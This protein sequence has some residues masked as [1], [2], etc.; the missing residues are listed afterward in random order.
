MM[1]MKSVLVVMTI[2]V[3]V[4][5]NTEM[6]QYNAVE[7]KHLC[8]ILK[9]AEGEPEKIP[10]ELGKFMET[11]NVL[12]KLLRATKTSTK[13]YQKVIKM[14]S[15]DNEDAEF[16]SYTVKRRIAY[17]NIQHAMEKAKDIYNR[18]EEELI[19]ASKERALARN[20]LAHAIYGV[21]V[22][23]FPKE[24]DISSMLQNVSRGSIFNARGGHE[25]V[26]IFD[27]PEGPTCGWSGSSGPGFTLIN[28][29]YC[30]CV[31]RDSNHTPCH[32]DIKGPGW[33]K[34]DGI[35]WHV[36]KEYDCKKCNDGNCPCCD[37][38]PFCNGGKCEGDKGKCY[39]PFECDSDEWKEFQTCCNNAGN[40]NY[41]GDCDNINCD[42]CN[43][44]ECAVEHGYEDCKE[45]CKEARE[46]CEA[47]KK[48]R[49]GPFGY[50]TGEWMNMTDGK[51]KSMELPD[52]W[53]H[54]RKVCREAFKDKINTTSES[55]QEVLDEFNKLL[56]SNK[57]SDIETDSAESEAHRLFVLGHA[58]NM[59]FG[60]G[61][62]G[63]H[64]HTQQGDS[65]LCI[66]YWGVS[67]LDVGI[68]WQN[69]M[70]EAQKL[71]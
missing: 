34:S 43:C 27:Y 8:K 69:Y 41:Q 17:E 28:D 22:G 64:K 44:N 7:F 15:A 24:E 71:S 13:T 68:V 45:M 30:L 36:E 48:C 5:G 58:K 50:L 12:E 21:Q 6:Q 20:S 62:H 3:K 26:T 9:V 55:I 18:M 19:Q 33:W 49:K 32:E 10:D 46:A 51:N 67:S 16:I 4:M 23:E 1:F 42:N 38:S 25:N 47:C 39:C 14:K 52:G 35:D 57:K 11:R 61:C 59:V 70:L 37:G 54:I 53:P 2:F 40:C 65:G 60:I 29:F 31:G 66:N 56:G 63:A